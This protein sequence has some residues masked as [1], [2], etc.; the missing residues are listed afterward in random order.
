MIF[1]FLRSLYIK[2]DEVSTPKGITEKNNL[3]S[4]QTRNLLLSKKEILEN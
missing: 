1:E 4:T 3:L 2:L